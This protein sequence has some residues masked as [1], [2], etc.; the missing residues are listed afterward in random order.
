MNKSILVFCKYLFFSVL[1]GNKTL[2]RWLNRWTKEQ[3]QL[4][5]RTI[6]TVSILNTYLQNKCFV[7]FGRGECFLFLLRTVFGR[8]RFWYRSICFHSNLI[9]ASCRAG[10]LILIVECYKLHCLAPMHS[11]VIF[12]SPVCHTYAQIVRPL[13]AIP[14]TLYFLRTHL[15]S[16]SLFLSFCRSLPVSNWKLNRR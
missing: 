14:S 2:G 12:F 16:N 7:L 15:Q 5:K 13:H 9:E 10:N 1:F 3:R 8:L 4:A 11:Y 6:K